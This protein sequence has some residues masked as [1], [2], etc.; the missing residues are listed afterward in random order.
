[1]TDSPKSGDSLAEGLAVNTPSLPPDSDGGDKR[2][3][4]AVRVQR[5][6]EWRER[7]S[8]LLPARLRRQHLIVVVSL[9]VTLSA[10][11]FSAL[12]DAPAQPSPTD[13][14]AESPPSTEPAP[15]TA[16]LVPSPSSSPSP[17]PSES[18]SES[19]SRAP[20][21]GTATNAPAP[22]SAPT[23]TVSASSSPAK[24][25]TNST[26]KCSTVQ[27]VKLCSRIVGSGP[28]KLE[29]SI[30]SPGALT[31]TWVYSTGVEGDGGEPTDELVHLGDLRA[32]SSS[33]TTDCGNFTSM[34][35]SFIGRDE[36]IE[37]KSVTCP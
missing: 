10:V 33:W 19:P 25:S 3:A 24:P 8:R 11:G 34:W 12:Q 26:Q 27:E 32:G 5:H 31:G 22:S 18:E 14:A 2:P 35:S 15:T 17:S 30:Y 4:D 28:F 23:R 6:A 9:A 37:T 13:V 20:A 36:T 21:G 16:A 1:M 7:A 29:T